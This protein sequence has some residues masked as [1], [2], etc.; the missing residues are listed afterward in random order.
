[1]TKVVAITR[2]FGLIPALFVLVCANT[3]SAA[4]PGQFYVAPG[5]QWMDFDEETGLGNDRG[6]SAGVGL[7][8]AERWALEV[9]G[10]DL[11]PDNNAGNE[12]DLDHYRVDLF[13]NVGGLLGGDW[14]PFVV[15]GI[16]NTNF[17]GENDTLMNVGAGCVST[18]GSGE[19]QPM[20]SN[21]KAA[22]RA[23]NREGS[24]SLCRPCRTIALANQ[25]GI[26]SRRDQ[27][28]SG[29]THDSG[30]SNQSPA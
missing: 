25:R 3:A 8:I 16:G 23:E 20:A 5:A 19:S 10:F 30:A 17:N 14:Q 1:M 27:Q 18:R 21:H 7:Q 11:D 26:S 6:F 12:V 9:A 15:G 22:G 2:L 28:G 24:W 29:S 4:E 13:Y